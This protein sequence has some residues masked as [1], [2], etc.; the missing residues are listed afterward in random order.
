MVRAATPGG[1]EGLHER[2]HLLDL[3]HGRLAALGDL[4]QLGPEVAVLVEV[5]DDLVAD[6][7]ARA[8]PRR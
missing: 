8:G 4:A 7:A 5:A 3:V 2:Q 6:A 1:I